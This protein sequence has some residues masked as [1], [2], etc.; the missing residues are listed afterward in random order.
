MLARCLTNYGINAGNFHARGVGARPNVSRMLLMD[1]AWFAISSFLLPIESHRCDVSPLSISFPGE[2]RRLRYSDRGPSEDGRG[3]KDARRCAG[4]R[5]SFSANRVF[6]NRCN[7][8][9]PFRPLLS[10]Y[11]SRGLKL[12]QSPRTNIPRAQLETGSR[13]IT[14]RVRSGIALCGRAAII[15]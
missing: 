4:W 15:E 5:S 10:V 6:S 8:S 12:E 14:F 3:R 11:T 13:S 1:A 7:V 2:S 9:S